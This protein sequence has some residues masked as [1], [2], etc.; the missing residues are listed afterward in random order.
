MLLFEVFW[1]MGVTKCY[2][3][4]CF[5]AYMCQNAIIY[6]VLEPSDADLLLFAAFLI[7]LFVVPSQ[8]HPSK[9]ARSPCYDP[10][11]MLL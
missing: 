1:N 4:Q 9:T 6:S 8:Y 3:L 5:E 2:Y 7:R 10:W 11:I